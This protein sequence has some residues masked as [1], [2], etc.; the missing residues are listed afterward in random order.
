MVLWI[1][2]LENS[3]FFK[4]QEFNFSK[5]KVHRGSSFLY[6]LS[7]TPQVSGDKNCAKS[8]LML[9]KSHLYKV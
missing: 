5:D 1:I 6:V 4:E 3:T 2:V 8:L 7:L 9:Y